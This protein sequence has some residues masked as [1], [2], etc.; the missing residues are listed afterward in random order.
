MTNICRGER[1]TKSS[2]H[3]D[4]CS[5][6]GDNVGADEGEL[7]QIYENTSGL[8]NEE[9]CLGHGLCLEAYGGACAMTVISST[10][11]REWKTARDELSNH[12]INDYPDSKK[13]IGT[14]G[15]CH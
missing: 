11:Q 2:C 6:V 13:L 8:W 10:P 3:L 5:R 15:K 9:E 14:H 12:L 4:A 1:D 7:L